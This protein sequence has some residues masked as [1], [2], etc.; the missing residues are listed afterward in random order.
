MS[1]V[2]LSSVSLCKFITNIRDADN[3]TGNNGGDVGPQNECHQ[4][5]GSPPNI[6]GNAN[7]YNPNDDATNR[8]DRRDQIMVQQINRD[9]PNSQQMQLYAWQMQLHEQIMLLQKQVQQQNAKWSMFLQQQQKLVVVFRSQCED[10]KN[11]TDHME[12]AKTDTDYVKHNMFGKDTFNV[13][14]AKQEEKKQQITR[15]KEEER[16]RIMKKNDLRDRVRHLARIAACRSSI[17][18]HRGSKDHKQLQR[19]TSANEMEIEDMLLE[20]NQIMEAKEFNSFLNECK[21]AG[22]L[23]QIINC[24]T[25]KYHVYEGFEDDSLI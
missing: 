25:A 20:L 24:E 23:W 21:E 13:T 16:Q 19:Q 6:N 5:S 3:Q 17:Y 2:S 8:N 7:F 22:Q 18:E 9:N 11:D 15:N 12:E 1:S 14:L 4:D 10:N